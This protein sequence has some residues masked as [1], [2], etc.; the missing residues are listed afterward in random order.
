[1]FNFDLM[2]TE[3]MQNWLEENSSLSP[4]ELEERAADLFEEWKNVEYADLGGI[5]VKQYFEK[6]TSPDELIEMLVSET[7]NGSPSALLLDRIVELDCGKQLTSLIEGEYSAEVKI[8]A[9]NILLE[10]DGNHPVD[11]YVKIMSDKNEDEGLRELCVETLSTMPNAVKDSLFALIPNA[12][13]ELKGLIAEILVNA[14]KDQ[15]ISDLL[16]DLFTN[17]NNVSLYAGFIAKY[18]DESAMNYLYKALDECNYA[19]FTEI[20][21]AIESLGGTVDDEYRDF[22]SDPFYKALKNIK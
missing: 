10:T 8:Q 7:E 9:I 6:I 16:E 22:S 13:Y 20:R 1:M 15:R 14:D 19:D 18:G 3:Y 17:G 11:K 2:F 12:D 4:D 21:N 5:S